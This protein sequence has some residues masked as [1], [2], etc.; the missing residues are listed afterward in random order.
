[1]G[2]YPAT[3]PLPPFAAARPYYQAACDYMNRIGPKPASDS[4]E[5]RRWQRRVGLVNLS[6]ARCGIALWDLGP[7]GAA[8]PD[9]L[10]L[11]LRF[12]G[13]NTEA[14]RRELIAEFARQ[15][16]DT[17]MQEYAGGIWEY[18]LEEDYED[19]DMDDP[20]IRGRRDDEATRRAKI[21]ILADAWHY[22]HRADEFDLMG[23]FGGYGE[24]Q[25]GAGVGSPPDS[26]S[27]IDWDTPRLMA[28]RGKDQS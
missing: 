23:G 2:W 27:A 11:T 14:L 21:A 6:I 15:L 8:D 26:I 9:K 18:D 13:A 1:M 3:Y 28:P 5:S 4:V 24:W 22:L 10:P 7:L 25:G 12:D 16:R 20:E 17:R 19:Q